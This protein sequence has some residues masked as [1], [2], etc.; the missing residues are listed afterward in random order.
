MHDKELKIIMDYA[1]DKVDEIEILLLINN[2]FSVK[3]HQQ[4]I[5]SFDY[6]DAKGIGVRVIKDDKM[7]YSYTENFAENVLRDVVDNALEN[8]KFTDDDEIAY[9]EAHPELNQKL[10]IYSADLEKVDVK[11]KI[12]FAKKLEQYAFAAD[13]RIINVPHVGL[14]DGTTYHRIMNNKGLDKEE[15][16]NYLMSYVS[17][18]GSEKDDKRMAMDFAI[19]RDMKKIDPQ[20]IAEKSVEKCVALLGGEEIESGEYPVIF[21]NNM[22]ATILQTFSGIFGAKAVHQGKSLLVDKIGKKIANDK[23]T[24]IDDALHPEGFSTRKFDSEGYPS[25]TTKLIDRGKL[26]SYLHNTQ[27]AR[28][29]KTRS[30]GNASRGYKGTLSIAPSNFFLQKDDHKKD[31]LYQEFDEVV[32]IVSL[33]GMHSGASPISGDFS[34]SAEGFLYEKGKRKNSLKQFTVSGNFLKLLQDVEMIAD[35]F[36]FN[37]NSFGASSV[38][39]KSLNISS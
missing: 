30:T 14:S 3:I 18:L 29:D 38:L 31:E 9:M 1:T 25:Q 4:N 11:A 8:A 36:R 26:L 19:T 12:D 39:V 22:M 21:D 5:E 17:V 6:A 35:D 23:I 28:K 33:Q 24:I 37:M 13:N 16:Q 10:D 20:Q 15:K 34:L 2:S 27:T 32:E 7:G